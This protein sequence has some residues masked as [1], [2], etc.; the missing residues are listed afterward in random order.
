ME[1][2]RVESSLFVFVQVAGRL[3]FPSPSSVVLQRQTRRDLHHHTHQASVESKSL[4]GRNKRHYA[5]DWQRGLAR[6]YSRATLVDSYS[7]KG[8]G[9][10]C[11][12]PSTRRLLGSR[13]NHGGLRRPR[14]P[15]VFSCDNVN[16][17][18]EQCSRYFGVPLSSCRS[19]C[20][21]FASYA[22]IS[23]RC[24]ECWTACLLRRSTRERGL[25]VCD[26]SDFVSRALLPVLC[27]KCMHVVP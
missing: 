13:N 4:L 6:R 25:C 26:S 1:Q 2:S 16:V 20:S 5:L 24:C 21:L 9:A 7:Q 10:R 18:Y 22:R 19:G 3:R 8:L 11:G 12:S 15:Q 17:I 23:N 27:M 14:R